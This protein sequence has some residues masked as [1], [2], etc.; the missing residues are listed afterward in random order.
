MSVNVSENMLTARE[1]MTQGSSMY[2]LGCQGIY[3][4]SY[5]KL[6]NKRE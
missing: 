4:T 3:S 5:L 1:A 6:H 2:K